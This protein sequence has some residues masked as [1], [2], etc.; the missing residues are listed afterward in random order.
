MAD[1]TR[2]GGMNN[3]KAL[4]LVEK[5]SYERC[6]LID[7][8]YTPQ[9]VVARN[10]LLRGVGTFVDDKVAFVAS[11]TRLLANGLSELQDLARKARERAEH[12]P[13]QKQLSAETAQPITIDTTATETPVAAPVIKKHS[14]RILR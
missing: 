11:T 5:L 9:P 4:A 3:P 14:K 8:K 6:V 10:G 1:E 7:T 12:P 2:P 13:K